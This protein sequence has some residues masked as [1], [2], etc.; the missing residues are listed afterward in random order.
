M[1][2]KVR[3]F[4]SDVY[5]NEESLGDGDEVKDLEYPS[6]EV[7]KTKSIMLSEQDIWELEYISGMLK[8]NGISISH[9]EMVRMCVRESW[10]N[11][12]KPRLCSIIGVDTPSFYSK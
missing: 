12:V 3:I 4:M 7:L 6:P 11:V 2:E 9:S 5:P 10:E 1:S 8:H